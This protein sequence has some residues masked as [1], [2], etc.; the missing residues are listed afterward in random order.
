MDVK[1][2]EREPHPWLLF[3]KG[4]DG[5]NQLF[6]KKQMIRRGEDG[7]NQVFFNKNMLTK[8]Q[9]IKAIVSCR[10]EGWFFMLEHQGRCCLWN[11]VTR[12]SIRL[13]SLDPKPGRNI[14]SCVLSS[15]PGD[16][17]ST[18]LIFFE[19]VPLV[20]CCG[21]GHQQWT[22]QS[23][24]GGDIKSICSPIRC[25]TKLYAIA[26][27]AIGRQ[28]V[29][30]DRNFQEGH[31]AF[32]LHGTLPSPKGHSSCVY[33]YLVESCGEI[34]VIYLVHGGKEYLEVTG[35]EVFKFDFLLLEWREVESA[36]DRVF[37]VDERAAYSCR[38]V[39]PE[40]EGNR[41]YFTLND[42]STYSFHIQDN[43]ISVS[44]PFPDLKP[45]WT[46]PVW[47]M[48]NCR[49]NEGKVDINPE[50]INDIVPYVKCHDEEA[51]E[52]GRLC[53]LPLDILSSMAR[54]LAFHDYISF[55]L[56]DRTC[57]S[58][59]PPACIK[60]LARNS[61]SPW[62]IF[63][64]EGEDECKL[65]DPQRHERYTMNNPNKSNEARMCYSKQEWCLMLQGDA[66]IY[67]WNPFSKKTI[68]LPDHIARPCNS[69]IG[70][71]ALDWTELEVPQN[72]NPVS[73]DGNV[74][75]LDSK[76]TLVVLKPDGSTW[77]VEGPCYS[78]H[79]SFLLEANGK[80]LG[81]FLGFMGKW[82]QVYEFDF[83]DMY[84]IEADTVGDKSL[85]VSR[86]S[87]FA[88][89]STR[90]E[91]KNVVCVPR[92]YEDNLVYY[93]LSSR[94]W[95]CYGSNVA[96]DDLQK[97]VK[98]WAPMKAG[99]IMEERK[100][101]D[102]SPV[103]RSCEVTN[104]PKKLERKKIMGHVVDEDVWKFRRLD[105]CPKDRW[106][107]ILTIEDE[108]L[109]LLLEDLYWSSLKEIFMEIKPWSEP[110]NQV[111]RAT[112]IE[113]SGVPLHC[114]NGVTLKRR[115][116]SELVELV[117]GQTQFEVGVIELGFEDNSSI[118]PLA[119]PE[120]AV[121]KNISHSPPLKVE[122]ALIVGNIG[123]GND[124][125]NNKNGADKG[126]KRQWGRRKNGN[127]VVEGAV[128]DEHVLEKSGSAVENKVTDKIQAKDSGAI[129]GPAVV[130]KD[131]TQ[132]WDN[133]YEVE[134]NLGRQKENPLRLG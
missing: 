63:S 34:F 116:I 51:R 68:P 113:L 107:N 11:P 3:K 105:T 126:N 96:M 97:P 28:L 132:S 130:N 48:S 100:N 57:R 24:T 33:Y 93:S 58:V 91:M 9:I 111:E 42:R 112:W 74:C 75:F 53:E 85:Y 21:V 19:S 120:E 82:L 69:I 44:L 47:V 5:R 49:H 121:G 4:E 73:C 64:K 89:T 103:E 29:E 45:P 88:A 7:R 50:P 46:S 12:E 18:I 36:E 109:Y 102:T 119:S 55:R 118:Q 81:V 52:A 79:Q 106:E 1:I 115:S 110:L 123:K 90:E 98:K 65:I 39:K 41:I 70:S 22:E 117:V 2:L 13:P 35:I 134:I 59:A 15:P 78:F 31:L 86:I 95:H 66:T 84:W 124:D 32:H 16:F 38:T 8:G 125:C 30:I 83:S 26:F 92:F 40:T 61:V 122:E 104:S 23:I 133:Y 129:V 37:V 77:E 6:F 128:K 56:V 25:N 67:L 10:V 43:T 27:T 101:E 94:T 14:S 108:D 127:R 87:S 80:L 131:L 71:I 99:S 54:R 20:M 114:W 76:G 72:T 17:D 60:E 62:L